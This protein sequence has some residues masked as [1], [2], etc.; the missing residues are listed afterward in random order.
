MNATL[1]HIQRQH[2]FDYIDHRL[3]DGYAT[4][5]INQDLRHFQAFLRFLQEQDFRVPQ[6]L[7]RIRGLKEPARL[8]RFLTS[9]HVRRLR[10]DF[11]QR[12]T[13]AQTNR[14]Q[15]DALL[16]RAT[17]YVLWHGG[18]RLG[19]VEELRLDDL[20]LPGPPLDGAPGQRACGTA[21]CT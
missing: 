10:D 20:D 16:D 2:V 19:E 12:V 17:F 11:E 13:D 15:R 9:E 18:L 7:L 3:A 8:P 5:G 4:S 14:Q 6:A 1:A 21:R